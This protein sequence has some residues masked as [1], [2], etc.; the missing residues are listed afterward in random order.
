MQTL[1][2][3]PIYFYE[4]VTAALSGATLVSGLLLHPGLITGCANYGKVTPW[5]SSL[6]KYSGQHFIPVCWWRQ[7][8]LNY[9]YIIVIS[10]HLHIYTSTF[11]HIL[12]YSNYS[13]ISRKRAIP[14]PFIMWREFIYRL[15][16]VGPA[17]RLNSL[18]GTRCFNPPWSHC[19]G[20][21]N[22]M[23]IVR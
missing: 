11:L 15:T 4:S 3:L 1:F 12:L 6:Q 8:I 19:L 23:I 22:F 7:I 14:F 17:L 20:I 5:A 16:C 9:S 18:A 10:I 21:G 2:L 13:H